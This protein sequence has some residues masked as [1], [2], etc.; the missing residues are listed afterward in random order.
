MNE[1]TPQH[2]PFGDLQSAF[3]EQELQARDTQYSVKD[4]DSLISQLKAALNQSET[5]SRLV[6]LAKD[7]DVKIMLV[8]S[9]TLKSAA[10]PSKHIYLSA[11][12]GQTTPE[13]PQTLEFGGVL[14]EMEQHLLG[15]MMP[16]EFEDPLEKAAQTHAK[17]LDKIVHMCKIGHELESL[18]GSEIRKALDLFGY[19]DIYDA[20]IRSVGDEELK[21]VY[22]GDGIGDN[23][24]N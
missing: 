13:M 15:Y 5:G 8:R 10:M 11:W 23:E 7:H 4:A 2:S 1:F 19:A 12:Q 16:G 9:E 6:K 14:R 22:L 18:Y 3:G 20:H 24:G 17:Y 21:S